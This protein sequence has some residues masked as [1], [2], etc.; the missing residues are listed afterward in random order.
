MPW[1]TFKNLK[2]VQ[3]TY[4]DLLETLS[5]ICSLVLRTR[6]SQISSVQSRT[7]LEVIHIRGKTKEPL[8]A[9]VL[10]LENFL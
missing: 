7:P 2:K 10:K 4:F 6:L 3:V 9:R 1:I 5:S 8:W